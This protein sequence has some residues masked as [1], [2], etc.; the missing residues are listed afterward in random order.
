M[1]RSAN[2]DAAGLSRRDVLELPDLGLVAGGPGL[3]LAAEAKGE[4]T[5]GVHVSLAPSWF[6]PAETT[7]IITPFMLLYALHDAMVKPM[8][9][10][11]LTFEFTLREGAKF[12][13][14]DPVTADDVKFTLD[15]YKGAA[16]ELMKGRIEAVE[17]VDPRHIRSE[18]HTSELQ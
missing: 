17:I 6:D 15:R 14:G 16:H 7:G 2:G 18:E 4:L 3:A 9:G 12:H 1:G 5:Y 11:G 13:N 10:D 8:P